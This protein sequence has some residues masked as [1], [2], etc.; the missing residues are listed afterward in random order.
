MSFKYYE[1]DNNKYVCSYLLK[2]TYG[3][4]GAEVIA[5][6]KVARFFYFYL[7]IGIG[8]KFTLAFY[9]IWKTP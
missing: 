5:E 3:R 8:I 1:N 6:K 2:L 4:F 9:K 7:G